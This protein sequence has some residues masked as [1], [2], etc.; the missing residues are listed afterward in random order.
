L[1]RIVVYDDAKIQE[2][3]RGNAG[4]GKKS[5]LSHRKLEI[6]KKPRHLR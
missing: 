2:D 1:E 3:A 5:R 6:I 4:Q